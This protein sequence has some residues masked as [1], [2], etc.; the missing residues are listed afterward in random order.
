MSPEGRLEGPSQRDLD[1]ATQGAINRLSERQ[2]EVPDDADPATIVDLWS[3]V[4]EFETAAAARG[5][6]SFTN[7]PDSSE[8]D[9][10]SCVLPRQLGDESVSDYARRIREAVSR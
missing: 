1:G 6:D 5:C 10:E 8:P 2:I 9:D 3:A 7:A 4:E